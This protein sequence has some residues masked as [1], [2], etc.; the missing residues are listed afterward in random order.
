MVCKLEERGE[1]K[2]D[3]FINFDKMITPT[4]IKIL[5]W[6]GV[7]L[8]TLFGIITIFSGLA[9]MFTRYGSVLVG[10]GSFL[11]GIVII[12][13]GSLTARIYCELLIVVFKMHE[14]L[15]SINENIKT[16]NE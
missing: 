4:I 3:K 7:G 5:F 11:L 10:F 6:I 16:T 8:S 15:E 12:I 1:W 2:M 14:S 13:V 9:Q